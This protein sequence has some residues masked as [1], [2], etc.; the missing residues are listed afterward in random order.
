MTT[1]S[2]ILPPN[3]STMYKIQSID[4]YDPLYLLRY[5]ELI[6]ASERKKADISLPFGFNRIITPHNYDSKIIDLLGVK[7]VL[8][9][10]D[11]KS[12]SLNKVFQEGATRIY[13]NKKVLPRA[14]FVSKIIS[15]K[16]NKDVIKLM[17]NDSFI[18]NDTAII[19]LNQGGAPVP[20]LGW[21]MGETDVVY[22]SENKVIVETVNSGMGFLVLTDSYYPTWHVTVDKVE[23]K[24][25]RTDYNFRGVIIP[26]GKHKIEF[27]NS[28]F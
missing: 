26:E 5:G 21:Q 25:Y 6:A 16:D 20:S 12:E 2:R 24:I 19:E 11:I 27:Y 7:F 28:L 15:A 10:S 23:A 18:P 14:F 1:D 8:S 13:E 22:Y 4:G 3:F 9:L 17:F